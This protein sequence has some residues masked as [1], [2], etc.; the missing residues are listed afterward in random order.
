M[1]SCFDEESGKKNREV[2]PTILSRRDLL[3]MVKVESMVGAQVIS[4]HSVCPEQA[5]PLG[6]KR[7]CCVMEQSIVV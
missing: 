6:F 7:K 1:A 3:L 2:P 5:Q 4:V